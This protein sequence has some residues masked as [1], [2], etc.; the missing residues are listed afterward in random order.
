MRVIPLAVLLVLSAAA[1]A[2]SSYVGYTSYMA[3][4]VN[5]CGSDDSKESDDLAA[6][7]RKARLSGHAAAKASA[8][9]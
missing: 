3:G 7:F 4:K 9:R 1:A 2:S 6:M 8:A 5:L